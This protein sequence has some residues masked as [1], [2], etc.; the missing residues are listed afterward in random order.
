MATKQELENSADGILDAA[1]QEN[2]PIK[3]FCVIWTGTVKP[4]LELVK[5]FTGAN[6]DNQ[7]DKLIYA[8]D[9]ICKGSNVDVK[10][11]CDAWQAFHL[12]G[13]LKGIQIFTGAKV[14]KAINRFIELSDSLCA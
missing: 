1:A 11:Y 12:K 9:G 14:D 2:D 6:V 5:V 4:V 10:N 3:Q 13:L 7:I 8:A